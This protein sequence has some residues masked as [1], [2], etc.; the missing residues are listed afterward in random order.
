MYD[1]QF[2]KGVPWNLQWAG[3]QY[4]Y[5]ALAINRHLPPGADN[6][7]PTGDDFGED[8]DTFGCGIPQS[9]TFS[10]TGNLTGQYEPWHAER[11]WRAG[12]ADADIPVFM[13]H[14]IHDNAARIPAA[15]WFFGDR[16]ARPGDKV[17]IGQWDHG[18]AGNTRCAGPDGEERA[19]PT[20]RFDQFKYALHAWF[21][22]HLAQRDVDTGPAVEVFLNGTDPIDVT[23]TVDP[24]TLGA[25]AFARNA[26]GD[27]GTTLG[28][29]PDA[30]DGSLGF[31][32]PA[33]EGSGTFGTV[34]EA[35]AAGAP[36]GA[37]EF[38]SRPTTKDVVLLGLPRM[39][40]DVSL[41]Y[42]QVVDIVTTLY[43][44]DAE[45]NRQAVS[46]CGIQPQLRDGIDTLTPVT[47]GELMS[48]DLQ[49][50][51]T[52]QV[53]PAG[54][55]LVLEVGTRTPHHASRGSDA[56]MTL[57]TGP[58]SSRYAIPRV[59]D[60]HLV[61]DV[62]LRE[63]V[64]GIAQ[65]PIEGTAELGAPRSETMFELDVLDGFDNATMH[66]EVTDTEGDIDLWLDRKVGDEWVEVTGGANSFD[67]GGPE[68]LDAERLP[69]GRYR[70]RILN[71]LS[72]PGEVAI[73]ITF[74]NAAGRSAS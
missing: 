46:F 68:T 43:R 22:K 27:A 70:L 7:S 48:L 50:F 57:H 10:G 25:K 12:A 42:G 39:T 5:E 64:A 15:E 54:Q 38:T 9:A 37:L 60:A 41:S 17:W 6:I 34:A 31:A 20:C 29:Y 52:A 53:I 73:A 32:P 23:E 35:L 3:P 4:A 72:V 40:L 30:T 45:G 56:Q 55:Q 62:R 44:Q 65:P 16:G 2:N 24:A 63:A 28:L 1:H 19:H 74:A 67:V 69:P 8:M 51:T 36:V 49:C 47:P 18:G 26:W 66:A 21:D 61:D 71:Y 58:E 33:E 13:V 59:L 11:D 14:G